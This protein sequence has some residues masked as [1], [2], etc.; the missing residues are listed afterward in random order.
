MIAIQAPPQ[1]RCYSEKIVPIPVPQTTY[2]QQQAPLQPQFTILNLGQQREKECCEEKPCCEKFDRIEL[3]DEDDEPEIIEPPQIIPVGVELNEFEL[4]KNV[5]FGLRTG[6]EDL[7]E[8]TS[9]NQ[10]VMSQNMLTLQGNLRLLEEK[11]MAQDTRI[12][13]NSQDIKEM[14]REM[15]LMRSEFERMLNEVGATITGLGDREFDGLGALEDQI[16]EAGGLNMGN[17]WRL[18]F[19]EGSNKDF[20]IQDREKKGYYRFR[21]TGCDHVVTGCNVEPCCRD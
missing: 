7:L 13:K 6:L 20:F 14:R 15:E 11:M 2:I 19:K 18:R 21:T 3:S 8:S 9:E 17:R 16:K 4:L 1:Q 10:K 12:V 5:V